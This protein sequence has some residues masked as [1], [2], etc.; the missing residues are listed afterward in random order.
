MKTE[1]DSLRWISRRKDLHQWWWNDV[2]R[3]QLVHR[4]RNHSV[5]NIPVRL[6][7]SLDAEKMRRKWRT[8]M[9]MKTWFRYSSTFEKF[10]R[11][12]AESIQRFF[13]DGNQIIGQSIDDQKSPLTIVFS[14]WVLNIRSA[15][16]PRMSDHGLYHHR[17]VT[18][19]A[20]FVFHQFDSILSRTFGHQMFDILNSIFRLAEH[21]VRW[22]RWQS[23]SSFSRTS[24]IDIDRCKIELTE[25]LM[26]EALGEHITVTKEETSMENI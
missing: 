3:I 19:E 11:Q 20:M 21:C 8:K 12:T 25:I 14:R 17:F 10:T 18:Q 23:K 9:K 15:C 7:G 16:H 26:K 4:S 5:R 22:N 1:L 13:I 24:L 6:D 2:W